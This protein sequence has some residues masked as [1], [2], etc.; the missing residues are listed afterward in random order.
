MVED[1]GLQASTLILMRHLLKDADALLAVVPFARHKKECQIARAWGLGPG[2]TFTDPHCNCGFENTL[3]AL[4]EH[5]RD[6]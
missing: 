6:E 5:L 1:L 4:P 2:G 3:A